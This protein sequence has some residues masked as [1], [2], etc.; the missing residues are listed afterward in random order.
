ME[1][2]IEH[3][4]EIEPENQSDDP[5][6]RPS[7]GQRKREAQEILNL[8]EELG[9]I[10]QQAFQTLPLSEVIRRES[11]ALRKITAHGARKRQ[12]HYLAKILR[13]NSDEVDAIRETLL[14]GKTT[15]AQETQLL[16]LAEQ[17]RDR[18]LDPSDNQSKEAIT[19]YAEIHPDT[20]LQ[21]LRQLVRNC[22]KNARVNE[23]SGKLE[24]NRYSRELFT[25]VRTDLQND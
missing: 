4:E 20:D 22:R 8:A 7:K 9:Q 12:L 19:E 2:K 14:L 24:S 6:E 13:K 3:P 17:W 1:R 23:D 10:S 15:V 21:S 5:T 16:H 25:W 11:E 18:F